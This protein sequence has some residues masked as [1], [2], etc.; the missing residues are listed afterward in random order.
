MPASLDRRAWLA[1]AAALGAAGAAR[2]EPVATAATRPVPTS[3][4]PVVG[5]TADG[6]HAFRGVRYGA[7]PVGPLRFRPPRRPEPWTRPEGCVNYAHSAMQ[8]ASGGG[9]ATYPGVIGIALAQG[10]DSRQDVTRQD[11][12]CLFLNVWTPTLDPQAKTPVMVW[13]HGGGFNYGS[14]SWLFY[15]GQNLARRHGVTVVTVNHRLNIFGYLEVPGAPGSG[16]AGQLDLVMALEWVRDNIAAFGGDPGRVTIFGQSGGGA[17]VSTLLATP[18]ARGLFHRAIIQSGPGLRGVPAEDAARVAA[19]VMKAAGASDLAG[20][21]ALPASRLAA[22]ARGA[23]EAARWAPVVDGTTLPRHPFEPDASP[24]GAAVPVLVG[25]TADERTL[26]NVGQPW[27]GRLSAAEAEQR[28][29]ALPG[30]KGPAL[31]AAFRRLRPQDSPSYLLTDVQTAAGAFAGS[32]TLAERK[33][34]QGGAPV[35]SYLWEWGA[36][37]EGGVMRAPHTQEIPF[38]FDNVEL[39]PIWLGQAPATRALARTAAASWTAFARTGDPNAPGLPRWPAYEAGRRS[40]MIFN[41]RPRL[42]QDPWGEVR[43]ALAA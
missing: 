3:N 18:A 11:E 6:V 33:A 7:P 13:F 26:Y 40:T 2:A 22:I 43:R 9:A 14:G 30:G 39:G 8:L 25:C 32:V 24:L 19:G 41:T 28:A 21:Q 31:M 10:M 42:E 12:D 4:G 15:S 1:G 35:W 5:T 29:A 16:N 23:G 38:V 17:K 27:W 20:L 36:P 37:V 34:A